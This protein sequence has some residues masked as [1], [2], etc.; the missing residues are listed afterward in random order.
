MEVA[1]AL[2]GVVAV[3][4]SKDPSRGEPDLAT[5]FRHVIH[6]TLPKWDP[7]ACSGLWVGL[8]RP[9]WAGRHLATAVP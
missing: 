5:R 6:G 1:D 4:D 9:A 8:A 3:R 2:L 7:S